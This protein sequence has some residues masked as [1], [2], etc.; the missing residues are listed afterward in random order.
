VQFLQQLDHTQEA[1]LSGVIARA[2]LLPLAFAEGEGLPWERIWAQL[3][4]AISAIPI[5]DEQ[6]AMLREQAAP[7]I[8]EALENGGS[9]YRLFHERA[10]EYL[11][12]TV[13]QGPGRDRDRSAG[14]G[15]NAAGW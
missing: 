11:R 7:F 6:I 1:G 3:A 10:A 2:A 13:D 8:V 14:S 5:N 9:V 15:S 4:T 12:S